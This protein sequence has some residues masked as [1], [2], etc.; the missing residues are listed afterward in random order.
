MPCLLALLAVAFPRI[1]IV[2]L[3][4]FTNFFTHVVYPINT[5]VVGILGFLFLPLTLIVYTFFENTNRGTALTATQLIFVFIAVVVDLG[6][7]GGGY[8][9]RRST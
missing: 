3:W 2:L 6:L 4:L 5:A 7:V 8:R 9:S 1:A